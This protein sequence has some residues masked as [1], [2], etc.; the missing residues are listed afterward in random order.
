MHGGAGIGGSRSGAGGTVTISGGTVTATGG[1]SAGAGIGGGGDGDAGTVTISG[2]TVTAT[3]GEST[4]AGIGGGGC[5]FSYSGGAGG[6]VAISGGTVFAQGNG[7][8]ADIG[9]GRDGAVVGATTFAGG[10]IRLCG[11]SFASPLRPRTAREQPVFCAVVAGFDSRR[12]RRRS[13][14]PAG[15]TGRLWDNRHRRRRRRRHLPVAPERCL[16]RL[17]GERRRLT[18]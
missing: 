8:G 17:H 18:R 2:G 5:Y 15:S 16:A 6:T 1:E 13:R 14:A 4:G 9:P 7:D 3:G 12:T 10:S 11:G